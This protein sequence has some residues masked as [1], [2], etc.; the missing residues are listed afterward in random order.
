[1]R[2]RRQRLL[3][4][5]LASQ[6]HEGC[7]CL[8]SSASRFLGGPERSRL[9]RALAAGDL[10]PDVRR[11]VLSHLSPSGA[12]SAARTWPCVMGRYFKEQGKPRAQNLE[13]VGRDRGATLA[14]LF[15]TASSN[16]VQGMC[17]F[18]ESCIGLLL[19]ASL[20]HF[21]P[22]FALFRKERREERPQLQ[23]GE[24]ALTLRCRVAHGRWWPVA[25]WPFLRSC[26]A[27]GL[28]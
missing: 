25:G 11:V 6:G 5:K 20:C 3:P 15:L 10:L 16:V 19:A 12:L 7:G 21:G 28:L 14:M 24:A 8:A 26:S 13:I 27:R 9:R 4:E 1:M 23:G 18:R 17:E 2:V 22:H